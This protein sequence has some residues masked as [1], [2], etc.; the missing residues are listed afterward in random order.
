MQRDFAGV[1]FYVYIIRSGE[2]RYIGFTTDL[3]RRLKEHNSGESKYTKRYRD[4]QV[5]YYEAHTNELDARRR[6]KYLKTSGGKIALSNML[7]EAL[8]E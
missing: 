4:W 2:Q 1:M 6:E 7:K 5:L 3:R 8:H